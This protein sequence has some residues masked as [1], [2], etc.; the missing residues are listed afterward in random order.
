M[1]QC[2]FVRICRS[3]PVLVLAVATM[4]AAYVQPAAAAPIKVACIGEH[5]THSDLYPANTEAQPPGMQEYPRLL[6]GV[7]GTGYDVRNFG[8]CCASVIQGYPVTETHPYL[9]G[10][11]YA[12]SVAF[13]PDIVVI[14]SWGRHDWGLSAQN[15]LKAF[16]IDTFQSDYE[17]LVKHYL[18]LP[19]KP[20]IYASLPIPIL[21]GN[22]GP[23]NGYKTSPA[24][25][26]IKAVAAKYGLRTIDL[27]SAFLG[28]PE[29]YRQ[30]P[31]SDSEGE[32]ASD[33]GMHKMA[34]LV[35]AALTGGPG[36]NS[37]AGVSTGGQDAGPDSQAGAAGG[38]GGTI[39][40]QDAGT[41]SQAGSNGGLPGTAGASPTGGASGSSGPVSTGSAGVSGAGG[42]PPTGAG[43]AAN[44]DR[45]ASSGCN[46]SGGKHTPLPWRTVVLLM[47]WSVVLLHRRR[48]LVPHAP[49]Y[50]GPS[51]TPGRLQ[52]SK[53]V[54]R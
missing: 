11:P 52:F 38:S 3:Y 9:S 36:N 50:R 2:R 17:D 16:T 27:Y 28:H 19:H 5:T 35:L 12:N 23:D 32:H 15:A 41:D 4:S 8:D 22:D 46:I 30:T 48:R 6:Q 51:P 26:A 45:T 18:A 43:A 39:G 24:S 33:A 7:I 37:D 21:A 1:K 40:G 49:S 31:M 44:P 13:A 20:T 47:G 10:Q 54:A 14:G 53:L 42:D 29:L 25:D 34:A